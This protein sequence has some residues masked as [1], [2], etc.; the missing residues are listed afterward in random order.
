MV[1][2]F[3]P[4]KSWEVHWPGFVA[5]FNLGSAGS[6]RLLPLISSHEPDAKYGYAPY[7]LAEL[8]EVITGGEVFV[9]V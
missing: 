7:A 2:A 3:T 6:A 9:Q 8:T 4:L 1:G 5:A